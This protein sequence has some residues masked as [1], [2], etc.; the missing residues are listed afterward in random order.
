MYRDG[1]L[2]SEQDFDF[3]GLYPVGYFNESFRLNGTY[4]KGFDL[5]F[6]NYPVDNQP[7]FGYIADI[8]VWDR[9]LNANEME[10]LSNCQQMESLHGNVVNMTSKFVISGTLISF[11]EMESVEMECKK[12][13][14]DILMASG[15]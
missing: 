12:T 6:G 13:H 15:A 14:K 7:L 2:V 3:I 11:V 5:K 8:N 10:Q 4:K 1:K 9:K